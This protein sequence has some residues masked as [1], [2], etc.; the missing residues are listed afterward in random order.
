L[1]EEQK[2]MLDKEELRKDGI[3]KDSRKLYREEVH[4]L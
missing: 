1:S 4:N 3:T 2:R